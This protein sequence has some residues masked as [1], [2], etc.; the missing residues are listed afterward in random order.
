MQQ[1]SLMLQVL[2]DE[3]VSPEREKLTRKQL[4]LEALYH[5][6]KRLHLKIVKGVW[7]A[8]SVGMTLLEM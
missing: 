5:L 3:G 1:V 2:H 8:Q 4:K 7:L 6:N